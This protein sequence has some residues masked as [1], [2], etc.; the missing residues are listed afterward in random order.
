M[1][2]PR[3]PRAISVGPAPGGWRGE[4]ELDEPSHSA[5]AVGINPISEHAGEGRE[6]SGAGIIAKLAH[7]AFWVEL[8][9]AATAAVPEKASA[10]TV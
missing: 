1:N 6:L 8:A 5:Q 4:V 9:H 3:A 2:R 7:Y 10:P